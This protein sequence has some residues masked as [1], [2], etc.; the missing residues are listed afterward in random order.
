[1]ARRFHLPVGRSRRVSVKLCDIGFAK[2]KEFSAKVQYRKAEGRPSSGDLWDILQ[3]DEVKRRPYIFARFTD[4][5]TGK[6][7]RPELGRWLLGTDLPVVHLNGDPTDFTLENLEARE[8]DRQRIRRERAYPLKVAREKKKA[9]AQAKRLARKPAVPDGLTP[10]QQ[11]ALMF[12]EDFVAS[13][14]RIAGAIV[15]DDLRRGTSAR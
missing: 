8:S 14:V 12:S 9:R 10:D 4:P 3:G 7:K 11:F 6:T 15:R 1:M 5:A 13:L 2:I